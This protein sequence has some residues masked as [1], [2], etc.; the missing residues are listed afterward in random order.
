MEALIFSR[1]L[2]A[3]IPLAALAK[4]FLVRRDT[5]S[6]LVSETVR[7]YEQ[8]RTLRLVSLRSCDQKYGVDD[9]KIATGEKHQRGATA[10]MVSFVQW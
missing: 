8:Y 9:V 10:T 2:H 1:L 7:M 3:R 5:I 4:Y 6:A